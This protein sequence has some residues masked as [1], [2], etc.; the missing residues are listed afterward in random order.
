VSSR[1]RRTV[2]MLIVGAMVVLPLVGVL[3]MERITAVGPSTDRPLAI[4]LLGS[5]AGPPRT[6][7]T[8]TGRAD[9]F[10]LLFVSAERDRATFV[11]LPRDSWVP[12]TG[13]GDNKINACMT[14]GPENCVTTVE[15]AFGIEIDAYFVTSMWGF[16][17]AVNEFVGCDIGD[18]ELSR[19]C[20]RG[21]TV[22]VD[23]TCSA[24]CGGFPIASRGE[25]KVSGFEALTIARN[26]GQRAAGDFSRSASQAELLAIAHAEMQAEGSIA[27][28][29]DALRILRR[30]SVTDLSLPQLTRLGLDAMRLDPANVERILAPS[31]I[32]T[33]GA[34]SVVFLND[35]TYDIISEAAATGRLPE[36]FR[37]P[38]TR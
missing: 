1:T 2:I 26:R 4:L 35:P 9:G 36:A 5:D 32:G 18:P 15:N 14:R 17:D 33:V 16:A 38:A 24:N 13:L 27:R 34:A 25:Q 20:T 19:T 10:Q 28:M 30:H 3:A 22:D 29:M 7:D 31:R 8:V 23:F 11:S 21:L 37:T 12:V 6:D